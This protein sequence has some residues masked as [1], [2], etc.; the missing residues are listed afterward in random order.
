M[1]V[2]AWLANRAR[3]KWRLVTRMFVLGQQQGL[4]LGLTIARLLTTLYGGQF[5]IEST[6]NVGMVVC[7]SFPT[8]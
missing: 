5:Q 7:V 2:A 8:A 3:Q 6:P 4:G 1:D